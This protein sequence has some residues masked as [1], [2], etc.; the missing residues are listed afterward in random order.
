ML[1]IL[2]SFQPLILLL[3]LIILDFVS[4]TV[5]AVATD[6]YDSSKMRKGLL[7]MLSYVL[8]I[9]LTLVIEEITKYYDLGYIYAT[10]LYSLVYVWIVITEVCSILEN[11][12]K[13]NPAL[14]DNSF[15]R[16]FANQAKEIEQQKDDKKAEKIEDESTIKQNNKVGF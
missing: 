9:T 1:E 8:A 12:V 2:Q 16:I 11:L 10:A 4:G 15:M 14:G 3:V 13:I 7:H 5:G 6:T